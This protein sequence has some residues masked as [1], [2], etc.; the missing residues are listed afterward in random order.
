MADSI[1]GCVTVLWQIAEG[2]QE[3]DTKRF[4][5]D[6]ENEIPV[7]KKKVVTIREQLDTALVAQVDAE[8]ERV[9]GYLEKLEASLL[10]LKHRADK[11]QEYQGILGQNPEE[12]DVLTETV[13]DLNLKLRLWR[14]VRDWDGL[15]DRWLGTELKDVDATE[16]EKQV[17]LYNKTVLQASKGLPGNPVVPNLKAKVDEFSPVLPVVVNLRN[18]SLKDRHWAQI[19]ALIGFTIQG[20][21]TFTL[22]KL[23]ER[24][25]TDMADQITNIATAAVQ[26]AVLEGMMEKV[27]RTWKA[28]EFEVKNY[29]DVKDLYILGDVSEIIA[30]LDD[31]LVTINTVLGSRYVAGIRDMVESWRR[32]LMLFQETLDEWM[33]CQRTWMYLE[34]IFS[35]PDIVRQLPS[36]AKMFQTVDKSFRSIMRS[37]NDDPLAI[38]QV[39]QKEDV[40]VFACGT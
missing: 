28:A 27:E 32:R 5:T 3:E 2:R 40:L 9:L 18:N 8:P 20:D 29:K 30:N 23:I 16:L 26:E 4:A 7:L 1:G 17:S 24:R 31:S 14:G 12:Y 13:A 21:D 6:I 33:M 36:A 25:M 10:A 15:M 19:H 22:G 38:K 11:L 37:V 35:S 39:G 34:T